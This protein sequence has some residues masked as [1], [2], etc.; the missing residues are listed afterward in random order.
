MRDGKMKT[1][2]TAANT[3]GKWYAA[4]LEQTRFMFVTQ[5]KIKCILLLV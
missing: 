1:L 2:N 4:V 5:F 3:S